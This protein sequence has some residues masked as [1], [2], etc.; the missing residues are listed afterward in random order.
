MAIDFR[1]TEE[2][3]KDR[4]GNACTVWVMRQHAPGSRLHGAFLTSA[5]TRD[6][7]RWNEDQLASPARCTASKGK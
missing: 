6:A 2:S 1:I 4:T 7:M 3:S 5:L